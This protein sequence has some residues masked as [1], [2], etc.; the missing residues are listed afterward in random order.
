[1]LQWFLKIWIR[2][3]VCIKYINDIVN[4]TINNAIDNT[5]NMKWIL[6]IYNELFSIVCMN[7]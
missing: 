5:I 2:N 4:N 7:Y 1:M 6:D 3:E